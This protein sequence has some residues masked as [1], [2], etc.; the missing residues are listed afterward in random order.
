MPNRKIALFD[1]DDTLCS[2]EEQITNDLKILQDPDEKNIDWR[3]KDVPIHIQARMLLI[4][5]QSNW[6]LKLKPIPSGIALLQACKSMGFTCNILTKG[7]FL[8]TN[9][10]TEKVN[11]C[12]QHIG[13]IDITISDQKSI[14][15][16]T[17]LVDDYP[18]Y[19]KQWLEF[20]PRGM[21]IMPDTYGNKNFSHP[22]VTRF[23]SEHSKTNITEVMEVLKKAYDRE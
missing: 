3:S 9:G 12:R 19:I 20:R 10:W 2:Y 22:R 18:D 15:Y 1:M 16:G 6:W 13:N 11:W 17:V 4:K 21:V 23:I 8:T 14:V 5:S 7:P